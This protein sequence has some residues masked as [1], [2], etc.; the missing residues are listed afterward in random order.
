MSQIS[1]QEHSIRS[2]PF[3][4]A[5]QK[6]PIFSSSTERLVTN[7]I[8]M[9]LPQLL[10]IWTR[11]TKKSAQITSRLTTTVHPMPTELSLLW[12]LFVI[13]SRKQLISLMP[14]AKKQVWFVFTFT[15]R[16]LQS[17]L[18]LLFPKQLKQFPLSTEQ[19]S[20]AHSASRF[21][22]MLLQLLK[23]QSSTALKFTAVAT[24]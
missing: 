3:S 21:I 9:R 4:A 10:C 7:T 14:A 23:A 5:R 8:T 2:I 13:Q 19:K 1:V 20:R 15:D 22:S 18:F 12:A 11:L 16:S 24:V 17:I 6:T